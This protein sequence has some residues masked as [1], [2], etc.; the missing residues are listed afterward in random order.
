MNKG[1]IIGIIVVIVLIGGGWLWYQ[2]SHPSMQPS[3]NNPNTNTTQNSDQGT[4]YVSVTDA[5]ANMGSVTAV[6]MT[7]DKISL[8]SQT[9][10]WV[11]V[12]TAPQT[13]NLLALNASGKSALAA[14]MNIAPDT[15]DQ[16][17]FHIATVTV[18]DAGTVKNATL[19]S[20]DLKMNAA[21]T[22]TNH[23]TT[24]ASLDVMADQSV[25][26]TTNGD[27]IFAPV[28]NFKSTSNAAVTLDSDNSV[29]TTGGATDANV[30][31]GMDIDGTVKDNF[32]LNANSNLQ[33]NNGVIKL[34]SSGT[35]T[36]SLHL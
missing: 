5:A 23:A 36:G 28:V 9:Q 11:T 35:A 20:N 19:P 2:Q 18:T 13:F 30:N 14:K 29:M 15:Y 31:A 24:A 34:G 16:V 7:V 6:N 21:V 33:L 8:H 12:S 32:K 1:L 4:L 3:S 27:I 22:V 25:H 10:G 17:W 26:K